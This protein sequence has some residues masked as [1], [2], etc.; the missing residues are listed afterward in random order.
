MFKKL[1]DIKNATSWDMFQIVAYKNFNLLVQIDTCTASFIC[2][3]T[4]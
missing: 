2:E 1:V 4:L 3:Y